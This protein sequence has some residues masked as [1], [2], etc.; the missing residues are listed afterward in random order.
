MCDQQQY[1]HPQRE[2]LNQY[3]REFVTYESSLSDIAGV[4][5]FNFVALN[6]NLGFHSLGNFILQ[7][8]LMI[9]ISFVATLLLGF[10]LHRIDHHIKFAPIILLVILI[11]TIAKVYHLPALLFILLLGLFMGT[12]MN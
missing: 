2:S 4:L 6:E 9:L 5:F 7:L 11:Y 10:M 8:L 3:N 1:S 12:S